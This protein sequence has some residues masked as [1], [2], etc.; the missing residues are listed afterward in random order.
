MDVLG[1]KE[2]YRIIKASQKRRNEN[3]EGDRKRQEAK[4]KYV[5]YFSRIFAG[6]AGEK[7]SEPKPQGQDPDE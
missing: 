1:Q 4:N 6:S 5:K 3:A 2:I 7:T